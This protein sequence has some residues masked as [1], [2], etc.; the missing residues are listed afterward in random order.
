[1]PDIEQSSVCPACGKD[2]Y[3]GTQTT[4]ETWDSGGEEE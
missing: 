1:L 3:E 4:F 2:I